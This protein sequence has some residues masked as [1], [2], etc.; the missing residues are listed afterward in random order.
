M[1]SFGHPGVWGLKDL[2][3]SICHSEQFRHFQLS[4]TCV[5]VFHLHSGGAQC[6]FFYFQ[7]SSF[8]TSNSSYYPCSCF[9]HFV[10]SLCCWK[11]LWATLTLGV[12]MEIRGWW[13]DVNVFSCLDSSKKYTLTSHFKYTCTIQCNLVKHLCQFYLFSKLFL[14]FCWNCQK[15][16]ISTICFLLRS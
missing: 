8:S 5:F 4:G 7:A 16:N 13:P 2:A 9:T 1:S 6:A 14:S 12:F 10:C 11:L 3:G 15:D